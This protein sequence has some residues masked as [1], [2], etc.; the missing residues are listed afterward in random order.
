M[1]TLRITAFIRFG[2]IVSGVLLLADPHGWSSLY[3][4][5]G[6]FALAVLAGFFRIVGLMIGKDPFYDIEIRENEGRQHA[7]PT[8]LVI[9]GSQKEINKWLKKNGF[10][11]YIP[12]FE[13]EKINGHAL[14]QLSDSE[15]TGLGIATIGEKK[16]FQRALHSLQV[17]KKEK[18]P[19][20]RLS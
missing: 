18:R 6:T 17:T 1:H 5:I 19:S 10:E 20:F 2:L 13:K 9:L 4:F 15:L 7:A 11:A 16:N 8:E 14:F 12:Q 3:G